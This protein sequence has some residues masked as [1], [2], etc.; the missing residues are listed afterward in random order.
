MRGIVAA[1]IL[2]TIEAQLN[3]PLKN[4]FDLIVGTS[5]GAIL[6]AGLL[7]GQS[8]SQLLNLYFHKGYIIFPY[9]RWFTVQRL[10]L[11]W[12][13]GLSAPKFSNH[14]LIQVIQS[15]IGHDKRLMDVSL[16]QSESTKLMILSYDT[17]RR[18]PIIFKSWRHEKWYASVPLWEACVCSAS[19]PTYFPAY[20]L[21]TS[22]QGSVEEFSMIDGGVGANNPTA[23]AVAE[24]IRLLRSE[25]IENRQAEASLDRIIDEIRVLSIGTGELGQSLPW[26]EVRSWGAIEWAP[27]IVDVIMDAPADIHRYIARQIVTKAETNHPQHYLRLQPKLEQK[28]GAIDNANPIYLKQLIAETNAYLVTQ[29]QDI[30]A[31]FNS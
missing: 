16:E 26:H 5:T 21:I 27:R 15:E 2:E 19:A 12:K 6:A 3:Q 20:H 25:G 17:V 31:F 30:E 22:N 8:P 11:I 28:F 24:A 13:Y 14:G 18:R 9:H 4:Y 7:V 29:T 23:C 10:G 1:R